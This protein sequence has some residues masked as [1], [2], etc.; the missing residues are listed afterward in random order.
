MEEMPETVEISLNFVLNTPPEFTMSQYNFS[1]SENVFNGFIVGN[2]AVNK[3]AGMK[4]NALFFLFCIT[5]SIIK[6]ESSPLEQN[7]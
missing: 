2:V 1:I 4:I 3:L 7:I 6:V 5:I